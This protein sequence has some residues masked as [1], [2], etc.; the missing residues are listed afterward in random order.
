[1]SLMAVLGLGVFACAASSIK[2][3]HLYY[4]GNNS[5][6]LWDSHKISIWH[7]VELNTGVVAGSL[8]AIRPLFRE[9]LGAA[10]GSTRT[11]TSISEIVSLAPRFPLAKAV[12]GS[13]QSQK[14]GDRPRQKG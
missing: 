14:D 13:G 10:A 12:H 11:A 9:D 8:P 4:I 5:D 1:M 6:W 2:T 3:V 7:V